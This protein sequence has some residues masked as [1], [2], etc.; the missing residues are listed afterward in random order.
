MQ[1]PS[2]RQ[3]EYFISAAEIG[4]F[5]GAA[6]KNHIA[7]PSLSEQIA[8]L[9]QS[10]E[11]SLFTRSSR[12]LQ[13]TDA[14]KQLLP[15]A[16]EALRS[17]RDF[18]EW[19]RRLR[20][21]EEGK[22][23]FGTFSSAH[24]YL[25]TDLIREFRERHPKVQV[26]VTG[27][28]SSEVAD[29]VR[30][31]SL[32]AGLVQLPVDAQDL[33]VSPTVFTD[34]VVFVSSSPIPSND[35]FGVAELADR[36]LILSESTWALRDPLRAS[37]F[38]RAQQAGIQLA[39]V[40]E[41]EFQTHALQLAAAGLGDTFISYHVGRSTIEQRGLH[42]APLSPAYYEHYAFVTKRNGAISPATAEFMRI[43]HR[44]MQRLSAV[45]VEKR[46]IPRA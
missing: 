3:L 19:S 21:V 2:I 43:A 33:V 10:L 26:H 45:P 7:Q 30:S 34:Q 36:P 25:L 12:G 40:I 28:N 1:L 15:L 27:L 20:S 39:P 9:E 38:E 16:Q 11:V 44:L 35:A 4:T 13:L 31:G 46:P 5:A 6:A 42:W 24:L 8:N 22:V 18:S 32:E 14:G 29:A 41:V 37:L 23:S 17:M